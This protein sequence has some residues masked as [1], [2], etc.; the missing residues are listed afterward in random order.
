M[1]NSAFTLFLFG[2]IFA[3][4]A[5]GTTEQW[6]LVVLEMTTGAAFILFFVSV[7]SG[8]GDV[9]KVPGLLPIVLLLGLMSL[10]L[11]PLP[12]SFVKFISP[13]AY[14][15]Y[16]PI[17]SLSGDSDW[18]SLSVD[19][20]ATLHE[21]LRVGT[22]CLMYILTVQLLSYPDKLRSATNIVV[23]LAAA[24][25]FLAIVQNVSSP[26]KI[27]WM[28]RVP[29]NA[30]PFGPWV[31]PNQFAGYIELLCPLAFALFLFYKPRV[32]GYES[33]REKFVSFFTVPGIHFHFFLG[34]GMVLMVL[35][36]FVSLCRGG[37][38]S[39]IVAGVVFIL[40]VKWKFPGRGKTTFLFISVCILLATS[41][42]GWDI[43]LSEFNQGFD[44]EGNLSDGRLT[45]WSDTFEIIK[46][47]PAFGAGFGSFLYIY[48]L[49]KTIG[50]S[51]IYDHAHNDYL[52]LLTDGG[53]IGITLVAW[54]VLAVLFHG[55]KLVRVRR[56]RYA[57]LVG[58]G[59]ISGIIALLAHSIT[60][61]NMHN[62]AVAYYFFFLCGLLVASVNIRFS[63]YSSSSLLKPQSR[64]FTFL[65]TLFGCFLVSL[66]LLTQWGAYSAWFKYTPVANIYIN[67][68]LS[69]KYLLKIADNMEK[70][71]FWDPL[72]ELYSYKLGTAK[73]YL[74][75]KEEAL[76][77]YILA[78]QKNPLEGAFLQQ[79]GLLV[80]D[81]KGRALIEEG[82]KRALDKESLALNY[83]EWLLWKG[84]RDEAMVVL[85][86]RL[87]GSS[88]KI[89]D[90][91]P[92][93]NSHSFS[94]QEIVEIL[95]STVDAWTAYGRYC[96]VNDNHSDAEFFFDAATEFLSAATDPKS[97]WFSNII[98]FYRRQGMDTKGLAVLRQ[99][100]E[101]IPDSAYFHIL[102]GDHYRSQGITYRAKEEFER[103]LVLEPANATARSRLRKMGF[104]DSY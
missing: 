42:F 29:E 46:N 12:A 95:P 72:E 67:K 61:F 63:H 71:V 9:L 86:D 1:K 96:E 73:W 60:D 45:L 70:A 56:D 75:E 103:A 55:W 101:K 68:Q 100:V 79:L 17:L 21:M 93:L 48:P 74:D 97:S 35:S 32:S 26:D 39:V 22:C 84:R 65:L 50:D 31:N 104:A 85:G 57:V 51:L 54:F 81:E 53:V 47:F 14:E 64:R 33:L 99:A 52:E 98:G 76:K 7:W 40:L 62:S 37:I 94:R 20:R 18:I 19:K 80:E 5:F 49:Y 102:L 8:K 24:I 82:Y 78:V 11:L 92:L 30:Q 44:Q 69:K 28:R 58:I 83:A 10:Q 89:K 59:C 25:A 16:S 15:V 38:L 88:G 3:P 27:Y 91:M 87:S 66:T 43:I 6:S 90:M 34:F 36:V 41:W 13:G 23:F 2:L 77:D 4:L